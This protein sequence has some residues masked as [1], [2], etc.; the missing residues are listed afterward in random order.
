MHARHI[1]LAVCM[2]ATAAWLGT[3]HCQSPSMNCVMLPRCHAC[4]YVPSVLACSLAQG[5]S[6]LQVPA[7][8][9]QDIADLV[10]HCLSMEPQSRPSARD[11]FNVITTVQL[12]QEQQ[13]AQDPWDANEGP[14]H[15]AAG[16]SQPS[17]VSH[18][19]SLQQPGHSRHQAAARSHERNDDSVQQAVTDGSASYDGLPTAAASPVGVAHD[20]SSQLQSS[21]WSL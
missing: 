3:K 12:A 9:P 5:S 20:H 13:A 1:S 11:V 14:P 2:H 16:N 7:E 6:A 4:L 17:A 8:C 18:A 19:N 21:D 15:L 10:E